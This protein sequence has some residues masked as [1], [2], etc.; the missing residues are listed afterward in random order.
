VLPGSAATRL[1]PS[2]NNTDTAL[3]IDD[4]ITKVGS[5]SV[6]SVESL[7]GD[8]AKLPSGEPITITYVRAGR[9]LTAQVK[10]STPL[11]DLVRLYLKKALGSSEKVD[12]AM[13]AKQFPVDPKA[14]AADKDG[15][16]EPLS[17]FVKGD[18]IELAHTEKDGKFSPEEWERQK[19]IYVGR[20]TLSRYGCYGCHDIPGFEDAGPIGMALQDWGRKDTSKLAP[21]HIA[22]Y[23]HHHGEV[24]GSS[25]LAR[26]E[27]AID[28]QKNDGNAS[29]ADLSAAF[30]VDSLLHHGRPGFV[31]QKLRDPR[32]YDYKK[33]ETKGWDERLRMPKFPFTEQQIESVAT[34]VV[35]LVADPPAPAYQFKPSGAKAARLEG[36]RLLSKY[37]CGGCHILEMPEFKFAAS[38]DDLT[39]PGLGTKNFAS[40][41]PL[42]SKL[43]PPTVLDPEKLSKTKSGDLLLSM[44]G[45]VKAEPDPEEL[46]EDQILVVNNWDHL[47]IGDKT[48]FPGDSITIPAT[49][50]V[51][52]SMG[53]GGD[54]AHWL[55]P[56][57]KAKETAG[58][59]DR[60]WQ[61][62]PP[63]LVREGV[64]VQTPWL[65][66]FLKEPH[67]IRHTTVLRMPKFNMDDK[68]A[69]ALANYFAAV[70]NA[71]FPYQENTRQNPDYLQAAEEAHAKAFAG[72][73]HDRLTAGWKLVTTGQCTKC[74]Q[75]GGLQYVSLDPAKDI[76]GPNLDQV[77]KRLRSDWVQLWVTNPKWVTPYTSMPQVYAADASIMP[78][79]IGGQPA[80]QIDATVDALLNYLKLLERH[81]KAPPPPAAAPAPAPAQ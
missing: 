10:V 47:Q 51:S 64:K 24:D 31:W 3:Q 58:D 20:K 38:L 42:L 41:L 61:A 7:N 78:E 16:V 18:E 36:E 1:E 50:V 75:V 2:E 6:R 9:T 25:T 30:F 49:K 33:I 26:V 15:K 19:L 22:E 77:E 13:A 21:E 43:I 29:P 44:H 40:A 63:P 70:D 66:Q 8:I 76:R 39:P 4:I 46:P 73:P 27:E 79:Y 81:G 72:V 56:Q 69:M 53:R 23:L 12:K 68:E 60:A 34:F 59:N 48:Y 45:L 52:R 55:A 74:H 37:N 11:D 80:G 57:L 14:F 67:Q 32:S 28:R 17:N 54:L 62:S 71:E 65:Y 5:T 35:G